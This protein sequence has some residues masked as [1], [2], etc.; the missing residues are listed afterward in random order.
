MADVNTPDASVA[1]NASNQTQYFNLP[2]FIATDKPSWL[3]DW[4]GAMNEIDS[5]LNDIA[6]ASEGAVADVATIQTQVNTLSTTVTSLNTIVE[7][8]VEDVA[9]M[10]TTVDSHDTR[11]DTI[12]ADLITQNNLIK[13]L[14]TSVTTMQGTVASLN[15]A[16][17]TMQ[18][19]LAGY[20]TRIETA[21]DAAEAAQTA[22]AGIQTTVQGLSSTVSGH[23]TTINQHT[24]QIT[25]LDGRVTALENAPSGAG[26]PAMSDLSFSI[27][28]N[29][30]SKTATT[31]A[32]AYTATN[33]CYVYIVLGMGV[34]PDSSTFRVVKASAGTQVNTTA[35]IGN[36]VCCYG[37]VFP[38]GGTSLTENTSTS[39]LI[40]LKAGDTIKYNLSTTLSDAD[41][42]FNCNVWVANA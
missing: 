33:D 36:A 9:A 2:L 8:A 18:T 4:N 16:V 15:T 12:E 26:M 11:M 35:Y 20:D 31:Q 30:T 10:Q 40:K 6:T 38:W 24:S 29:I 27:G 7:T 25:G 37:N 13:A 23:T 22:V 21:E 39:G 41:E 14:S 42:W 3:V 17:E 28:A 19:T 5:I 32:T 34:K 1:T